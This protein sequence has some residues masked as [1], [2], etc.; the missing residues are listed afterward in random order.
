MKRFFLYLLCMVVGS[1][2]ANAAN[3]SEQQALQQALQFMPGKHF[4]SVKVADKSFA[5]SDSEQE[6]FYIF[7]ASDKGYVIVSADD[8]TVPILGYSTSGRVDPDRMPKNLRYWLTC[9]AEQINGLGKTFQPERSSMTRADKPAIEPLIKATWNQNEPYNLQCPMDEEERSATGCVATALAQAMYYYKWPASCP[10]LPAYTTYSKSISVSALPATTFKWDQMKDN[11]NLGET[12]AAAD[13]VAELMRYCGQIFEMDYASPSSLG[14]AAYLYTEPVARY[15]NYSSDMQ[16]VFRY[17]FST[18]QWEEL[19]YS[20]LEAERPVLYGG[21]SASDGHQFICDGY[22][23]SGLFHFNWGWSGNSDGYFVLSLA[24][25]DEKGIGGGSSSDGYTTEQSAIIGFRPAAEGEVFHP[26][27]ISYIGY[28]IPDQ[29][30]YTRSSVAEDFVDVKLSDYVSLYDY[31]QTDISLEAGWGFWQNG[32]ITCL[33]SH[34]CVIPEGSFYQENIVNASFGAD[35]PDGEYRLYQL[36]RMPGETEWHLCSWWENCYII[37]TISGTDL[38]LS[39]P[40]FEEEV[41]IND[42]SFIDPVVKTPIKVMVNLINTGTTMQEILYL[43]LK[44]NDSWEQ[45]SVATG[46]LE[47][48][49]T[50]DVIMSFETDNSGT[51]D[52]KITSDAKGENVLGRSSVTIADLKEVTVGGLRYTYN[53]L[54]FDAQVI[55]DES[56]SSLPAVLTIPESFKLDSGQVC[57]V[58]AIN[59]RAFYNCINLKSVVV[60]EGVKT[61]G[62]HAFHYCFELK[63][64]ELPSTLESLGEYAFGSCE[65]LQEVV[66]HVKTPFDINAN[67]FEVEDE[68]QGGT[69]PPTGTLYVP[70]GTKSSYQTAEGWKIFSTIVEMDATEPEPEPEPEPDPTG[71]DEITIGDDGPS[72]WY[73][74]HGQRIQQ[75]TKK[76]LYIHNDQKVVIR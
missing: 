59:K 28:I 16:E 53:S 54:T 55:D 52:V 24:N 9:Y 12:G 76:G 70:F 45:V 27:I 65:V 7:N 63:K 37:A 18:S 21:S 32:A 72:I 67:V 43:W 73:D 15:F 26:E 17:Y 71:N 39:Y 74:L 44:Q 50:G 35:L 40:S 31:T 11:Y 5:R 56:Y 69:N 60:S 1:V 25:P 48:G 19:I 58:T 36:F 14:S 57:H 68:E 22:D 23:G 33:A 10:A 47:P 20:E 6:T 8:R 75:P 29:M 38:Q 51:F 30:A 42:I 2:A 4:S 61:I 3:V 49:Q 66:S 46:S 41:T 62:A 34:E 64:I 13:A